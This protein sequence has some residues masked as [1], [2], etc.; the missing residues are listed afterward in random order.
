MITLAGAGEIEAPP[1]TYPA[2]PNGDSDRIGPGVRR[3][4]F[5]LRDREYV[6]LLAHNQHRAVKASLT[7]WFSPEMLATAP[8]P[9]FVAQ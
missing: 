5:G 1:G 8:R 7:R 4:H 3:A 9:V 6:S 2:F